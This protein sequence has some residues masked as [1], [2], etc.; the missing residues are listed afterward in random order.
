[1]LLAAAFLTAATSV[2]GG[3]IR[4]TVSLE[5][6]ERHVFH[7]S[8]EIPDVTG[9]VTVQMPAWNALY[10]IRDFSAHM[11][12][13]EVSASSGSAGIEKLDKLTWRVAGQGTVTIRYASY[14]DEPGPFATQLNS[15]HAF[16][17]PAMILMYVPSRRAEKV[18]MVLP[19]VPQEWQA[20]GNAPF[21]A[22]DSMGG[23]RGFLFG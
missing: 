14:W 12:E 15:E 18:E 17:N 5:H 2:A 7:V 11:R 10:Q 3:T 21:T 8:M 9:E 22:M 16:I 4:Y 23:A 6:P 19:D 13:V 1:M 20:V